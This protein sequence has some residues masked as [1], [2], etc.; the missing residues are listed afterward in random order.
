MKRREHPM[1]WADDA[2]GLA[3]PA[4]E[5][6]RTP[7]GLPK[8]PY[9][10]AGKTYDL[11]GKSLKTGDFMF[12]GFDSHNTFYCFLHYPNWNLWVWGIPIIR[13][14]GDSEN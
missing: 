3:K 8:S 10:L 5:S 12:V 7:H 4:H 13:F 2:H 11:A 6:P 1:V 14:R 9:G